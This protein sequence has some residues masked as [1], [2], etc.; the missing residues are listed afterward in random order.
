MCSGYGHDERSIT[1][2]SMVKKA[3]LSKE[4]GVGF[5]K[6]FFEVSWAATWNFEKL[7]VRYY[8][9]VW[10]YEIISINL[11]TRILYYLLTNIL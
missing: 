6:I 4:M 1:S 8:P 3:Q 2:N 5:M 11:N 9:S 7:F 10:V